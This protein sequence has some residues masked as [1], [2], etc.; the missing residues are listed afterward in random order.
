M[1]QSA[2]QFHALKLAIPVRVVNTTSNFLPTGASIREG[3]GCESVV[4]TF[5]VW[6]VE[7][8]PEEDVL[9][10]DGSDAVLSDTWDGYL[11]GMVVFELAPPA[12]DLSHDP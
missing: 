1:L 10:I 7:N 3:F 4:D 12:L 9:A 6:A 11:G 2:E 5:N 8:R